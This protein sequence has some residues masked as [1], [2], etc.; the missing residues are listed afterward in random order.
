MTRSVRILTMVGVAAVV[1]SSGAC[2]RSSDD[3]AATRRTAAQHASTTH[4]GSAS[5]D[6]GAGRTPSSMAGPVRPSADNPCRATSAPPAKY[7]HVLVIMEE[8]R[9]WRDVG[10]VGFRDPAMPYLHGLAQKCTTFADWTETDTS[11]NS[12]T[13][14]IGLT[15]GVSN[16]HT[17]NDCSPSKKCRSTDDNIFRQVRTSGGSA[18][19]YVEGADAPCSAAGNAARHVPALY[20]AGSY[21]DTG[22]IHDDQDACA[23]EVRP[24][25]DLVPSNLPT[26]AVVTPNLCNDGH[27]CGNGVVDRWLARFLPSILNGSSY[28]GGTTAVMVLYDEDHPVP[29][30][31][32]APTARAG[33]DKTP[34]AGHTAMLRTWE[35]MLG[36]PLLPGVT[37]AMSLRSPANI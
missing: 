36:L 37:S 29:N 10:G 23:T 32:V 33:V 21:T 20:Y 25:A 15:R 14:Y 35:E 1:V 30:L 13:Q 34:G 28:R 16:P 2:A 12:L 27:D 9:R 6:I 24:L 3:D 22:G 5:S 31:L 18:R 4:A 17:T 8:N 7:D 11:Q 26:F 19:S